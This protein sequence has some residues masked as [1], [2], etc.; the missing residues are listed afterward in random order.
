MST[1]APGFKTYPDHRV[2]I[3]PATD[4]IRVLLGDRVLADSRQALRVDET[5]HG[6]V[7]YLPLSDVAED[8]LSAT[9]H[10][11]YCPFKGHARYWT[12]RVGGL[13]L[14]NAVWAY[15]EPFEECLALADHVA[16]YPDRVTLEVNGQRQ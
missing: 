3:E 16:F 12:I 6:R 4:R 15:P 1:P 5:R 2:R 11:S 7:W 10:T 9:A 13:E 8:C 14:E